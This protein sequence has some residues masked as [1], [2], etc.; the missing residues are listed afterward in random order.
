MAE[1]GR[2]TIDNILQPVKDQFN[3]LNADLDATKAELQTERAARLFAESKLE[4]AKADLEKERAA[5]INAEKELA[6]AKEVAFQL[7]HYVTDF[8]NGD[9]S[10]GQYTS[11]KAI[12]PTAILLKKHQSPAFN[13]LS[14]RLKERDIRLSIDYHVARSFERYMARPDSGSVARFLEPP[15]HSLR[16]LNSEQLG[17]FTRRLLN[18]ELLV[19]R[20]VS[21]DQDALKE[22]L[23]V[24][25]PGTKYN[26]N[27]LVE[28][29]QPVPIWT[30]SEWVMRPVNGGGCLPARAGR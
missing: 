27:D 2:D 24:K 20:H 25:H 11:L 18:P 1:C 22:Y 10:H 26:A 28:R 4:E 12:L 16:Q 29:V 8:A 13:S 3:A 5:K 23:W 7:N 17:Q 6:L 15:S 19:L 14:S 21:V 30:E 9:L